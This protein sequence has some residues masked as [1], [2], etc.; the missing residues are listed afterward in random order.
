MGYKMNFCGVIVFMSLFVYMHACVSLG[1]GLKMI[2][3]V[4]GE[5]RK[6]VFTGSGSSLCRVPTIKG[7]LGSA[8][9]GKDQLGPTWKGM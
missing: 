6:Y 4:W 1:H 3:E 8:G 7:S 5:S 2:L 9:R